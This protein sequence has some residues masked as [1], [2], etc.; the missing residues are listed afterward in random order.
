MTALSPN[1]SASWVS[2]SH[3]YRLRLSLAGSS[4]SP[5][6]SRSLALRTEPSPPVAL[7]LASRRRSYVRLQ[8]GVGL[9]GEVSHLPRQCTLTDALGRNRFIAPSAC[10]SLIDVG[11]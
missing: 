11:H 4:V 10:Q 5:A 2:G 8:V 3:R 7:H 1:P 6:E 9:P